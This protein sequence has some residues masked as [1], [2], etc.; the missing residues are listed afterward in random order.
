[1]V[2]AKQTFQNKDELIASLL[3]ENYT[4]KATVAKLEVRISELERTA[5]LNSKTSSK[6]PSSDGL[7]KPPRVSLRAKSS[8]KKGGQKGHTGK[9][10]EQTASPDKVIKHTVSSCSKCNADLSGQE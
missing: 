3:A 4:L 7:Q 5:N 9:T 6:P 8:K 10:L 1:M 2:E